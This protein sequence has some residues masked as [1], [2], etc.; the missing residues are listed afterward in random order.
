MSKYQ[1]YKAK[2]K[3]LDE[4]LEVLDRDHI[5]VSGINLPKDPDGNER[6]LTLDKDAK[7]YRVDKY[8]H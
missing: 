2:A 7:R 3:I 4:L 5:R 1:E 8:W 6:R